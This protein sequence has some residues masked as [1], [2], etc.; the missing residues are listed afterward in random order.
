MAIIVAEDE[1][2]A[3]KAKKLIKVEYEVFEP[4]LD[5]EKI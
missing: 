4:L 2:A 5:P 3:E 1:K